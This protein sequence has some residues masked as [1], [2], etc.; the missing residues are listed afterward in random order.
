[1][2]VTFLVIAVA[3][4]VGPL[5][6]LHAR[7]VAEKDRR[8][9]AANGTLETAVLEVDRRIALGA[10]DLM[11]AAK[12]ALEAAKSAVSTI[13]SVSTWPWRPETFRGFISALVVPVVVWVITALLANV[14][15]R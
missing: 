5:I 8:L 6:G 9:A 1:M 7:I 3:S 13:R 11:P 15:G 14:I 4:F 12:D 10:Y 2:V